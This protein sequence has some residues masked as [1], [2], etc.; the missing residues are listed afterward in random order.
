MACELDLDLRHFDNEQVFRAI[1]SGGKRIHAFDSELRDIV[2]KIVRLNKTFWLEAGIEAM[3]CAPYEIFVDSLWFFCCGS[4]R[5]MRF[6]VE[7][8]RE[9]S[10]DHSGA[11]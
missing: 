7:G 6:P 10:D 4:G 5:C 8:R 2:G 9:S 11:C 1:R 3:A